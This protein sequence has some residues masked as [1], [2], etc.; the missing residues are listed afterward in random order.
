MAE[1][2]NRRIT[3]DAPYRGIAHAKPRQEHG[4]E[5]ESPDTGRGADAGRQGIQD[6]R[7]CESRF[8]IGSLGRGGISEA[9]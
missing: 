9:A 7:M 2:F 3:D 4:V 5:P 8:E 6:V 1:C